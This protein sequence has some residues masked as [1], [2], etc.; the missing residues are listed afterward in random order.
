MSDEIEQLIVDTLQLVRET[1]E[2]LARAAQRLQLL[3]QQLVQR[4]EPELLDD[5]AQLEE[6]A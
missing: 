1:R 3:Q 6:R 4:A 5:D 2:K